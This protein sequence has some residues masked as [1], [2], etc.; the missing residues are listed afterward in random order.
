MTLDFLK[1]GTFRVDVAGQRLM[2]GRFSVIFET[3][4]VLDFD[5]SSPKTGPVTNRASIVGEELRITPME[6]KAERYKRVEKWVRHT[7]QTGADRSALDW[8]IKNGIPYA[9]WCPKGRL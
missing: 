9:D 8:A 5:A 6:G 7:S 1:D 4:L 3:Q 2:G